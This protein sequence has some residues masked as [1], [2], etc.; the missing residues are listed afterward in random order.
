MFLYIPSLITRHLHATPDRWRPTG[1]KSFEEVENLASESTN[2][3][4]LALAM[5]KRVRA[6]RDGAPCLVPEIENPQQNAVKAAMAEFARGLI[7][8]STPET[9]HIDQGVNKQ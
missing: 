1:M 3:Y 8:Y 2:Q 5:A 4:K 6:L 9:Q 7:S